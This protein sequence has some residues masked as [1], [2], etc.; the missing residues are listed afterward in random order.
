MIRKMPNIIKSCWECPF[1]KYNLTEGVYGKCKCLLSEIEHIGV[2]SKIKMENI[3][4]D[5]Y[6]NKCVLLSSNDESHKN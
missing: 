5:W 2:N 1:F 3:V 6:N 4:S